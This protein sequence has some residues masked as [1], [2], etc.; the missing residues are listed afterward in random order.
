V[1]LR[2]EHRALCS[3]MY[4][5][6][7]LKKGASSLH[8]TN[9]RQLRLRRTIKSSLRGCI[10]V[11]RYS[12]TKI[13]TSHLA[14]GSERLLA[15]GTCFDQ[16]TRDEVAW[17]SSPSF[18]PCR[19]NEAFRTYYL[20]SLAHSYMTQFDCLLANSYRLLVP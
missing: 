16:Q 15:V 18:L 19:M 12:R 11:L 13:L 20:E 17:G 4:S 3:M 9:P 6:K 14:H 1:D 10:I 8:L 2:V 7:T 5:A